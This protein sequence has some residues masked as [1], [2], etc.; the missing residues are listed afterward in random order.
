MTGV[1][2][3]ADGKALA[4][5]SADKSVRL[6]DAATGKPRTEWK[7]HADG[8]CALACHAGV[9]ATGGIDGTV[10]LRDMDK[11]GEP[12]SFRLPGEKAGKG[13]RSP[14]VAALAFSPDGDRL[15]VAGG[16][17]FGRSAET[18]LIYGR[19]EARCRAALEGPFRRG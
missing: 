18:L 7:D 15:A 12:T 3:S 6:R 2:F 13:E 5:G 4:S 11:G 19:E 1:A 16:D 14:C 10:K 17:P 8:V 9:L